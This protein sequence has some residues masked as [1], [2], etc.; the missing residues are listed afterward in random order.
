MVK[1]RENKSP[2]NKSVKKNKNKIPKNTTTKNTTTKR[3]NKNERPIKSCIAVLSPDKSI[4]GNH[5]R[6]IVEFFQYSKNLHIKYEI[7]GLANGEHGFHIHQCGDLTKGC[8]SGCSHFNPH[9]NNHSG[10]HYN[11]SHAGDLGNI[12]SRN[13]I[14]KGTISTDKVT[15]R[16]SIRNI[17][18]RMIIVH[19]DRDDIGLGGDKESLKTGNAG[20]RLACGIIGIR[21][22]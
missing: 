18:G 8:N 1:Y 12:M 19:R 6:G 21:S 15:L 17:I 4:T 9:G 10:L 16:P 20:K 2:K 7:T 13:G 14:A 3:K 22:E 11:L 5:V